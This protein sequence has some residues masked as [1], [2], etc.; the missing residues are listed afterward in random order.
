MGVCPHV[1]PAPGINASPRLGQWLAQKASGTATC[2]G[3]RP[4]KMRLPG[5]SPASRHLPLEW[6]NST[7]C[8]PASCQAPCPTSGTQRPQVRVLHPGA[9]GLGRSSQERLPGGGDN[10][11]G[12]CPRGSGLRQAGEGQAEQVNWN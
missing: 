5:E 8:T 3:I 1:V 6:I 11:P 12:P 4:R 7:C 2:V 9:Q 10:W